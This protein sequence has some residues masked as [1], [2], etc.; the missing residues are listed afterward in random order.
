[1][2]KTFNKAV[3]ILLFTNG[4][5]LLA[6]AMIGPIYAFFVESVGGN[7]LDASLTGAAFA[8]ATGITLLAFGKITDQIKRKYLLIVIGYALM[9]IGYLAFIW[10]DSLLTLLI[11]QIIIG[12][13]GAIYAPA[14]DAL[15]SLNLN[16]RRKG[17]GWGTWEAM[18]QFAIAIGSIIGGL[19]AT[20]YGF[21]LLFLAM[22]LLC[23]IS[24][25]YILLNPKP[26]L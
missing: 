4:F 17:F 21:P 15:Y 26:L 23:F 20:Y 25:I 22:A 18:S 8:F 24:A 2:V 14:F 13:G 5:I 3:K 6:A 1:M 7:L 12:I 19:I 9:G 16:N 11:V 10:V